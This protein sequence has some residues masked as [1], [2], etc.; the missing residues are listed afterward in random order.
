[1]RQL[2]LK[3]SDLS[4]HCIPESPCRI[5][6]L[7]FWDGPINGVLQC[8]QCRAEYLFDWI[9][10]E[11][12]E[13]ADD[14]R[15]FSLSPLPVGSLEEIVD[16][17]PKVNPVSWPIW[18]PLWKFT[19]EE[20]EKLAKHQL[21]QILSKAGNPEMIMAWLGGWGKAIIAVKEINPE[22]IPDVMYSREH[23]GQ[24]RDWFSF[25]NLSR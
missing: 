16:A 11:E 8:I 25:M 17:C 15:I 7:G 10:W 20:E 3:C 24:G 9:D 23:R 13:D 2:I 12:K 6:A 5:V 18:I 22:D 21:D 1:M 14:I 19:S 4:T